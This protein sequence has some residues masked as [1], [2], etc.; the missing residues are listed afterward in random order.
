MDALKTYLKSM[1]SQSLIYK[2]K[3]AVTNLT[4]CAFSIPARN[5]LYIATINNVKNHTKI[6]FS[7][8][9]WIWMEYHIFSTNIYSQTRPSF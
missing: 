4:G 5:M 2:A 8:T 7:A 9:V 6:I 3:S 1:K